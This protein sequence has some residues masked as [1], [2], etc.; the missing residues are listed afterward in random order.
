MVAHGI[1]SLLRDLQAAVS[2]AGLYPTEHPRAA[3]LRR[4]V[5]DAVAALTQTAPEVAIFADDDRLIVDG[6][7]WP[8]GQHFTKGIFATLAQAGCPRLVL[9]R[10][11]TADELAAFAASV[12]RSRHGSAGAE[13]LVASDH[14]RLSAA[15]A[16]V[17]AGPRLGAPDSESEP[18]VSV[19]SA[20]LREQRFDVDALQF[21]VMSIGAALEQHAHALVPLAAL[22]SHDEYTVT[23][24]TN[25][26]ML[27]MSLGRALG[28]SSSTL[29]DLG[30]AALLHDV[31]KLQV[32]KEILNF[33]GRLD[34]AQAAIVR[35]HP[36]EGARILLATPGV[37]ELAIAVAYE[38][39]LQY[40]G[41][42]YPVVPPHWKVNA[43]SH[44]TMIADVYDALRTDRPYRAG[45]SAERIEMLMTTEAG[46]VFDPLMLR[47][48]FERVV[49]RVPPFDASA[50][51]GRDASAASDND[52]GAASGDDTGAASGI[53][54]ADRAEAV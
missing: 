8:N 42:G 1:D 53:D 26:A 4:R 6:R 3:E 31:G 21:V 9:H 41:G 29:Q 15:V 34:E 13:G 20:I 16:G 11:L 33:V 54:V 18:L 38:H 45:L 10:G 36:V 12:A 27:A 28:V 14:I 24:I 51:S 43:G 7:V 44:M 48:F 17:A 23:H 47:V 52:T 46:T 2:V 49:P 37:P 30:I 39:H 19:W 25:V 35:R 32:P 50:T 40:D 5:V 22:R